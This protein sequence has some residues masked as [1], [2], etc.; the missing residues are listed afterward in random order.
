M[1]QLFN[2]RAVQKHHQGGERDAP[3]TLLTLPCATL[4]LG[5]LI[6]VCGAAWATFVRFLSMCQVLGFYCRSAQPIQ[7]KVRQMVVYYMFNKPED[8]WHETARLF[9][10]SPSQFSDQ[11]VEALP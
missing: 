10:Q 1:T 2:Q 4:G 3:V 8:D 6:A 5:V 11:E 9:L 7:V